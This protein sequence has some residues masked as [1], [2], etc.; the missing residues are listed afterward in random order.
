MHF[1]TAIPLSVSSPPVLPG[2][3]LLLGMMALLTFVAG[4]TFMIGIAAHKRE[5]IQ[6]VAAAYAAEAAAQSSHED[7]LRAPLLDSEKGDSPVTPSPSD[8]ESGLTTTE[9]PDSPE[10]AL[11]KAHAST[12]FPLGR[13]LAIVATQVAVLSVAVVRERDFCTSWGYCQ[14][15]A[16]EG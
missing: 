14:V 15:T 16:M 1:L 4:K 5:S 3:V 10:V 12:A 7:L 11:L 8:A 2:V 9:A 6:R 13:F